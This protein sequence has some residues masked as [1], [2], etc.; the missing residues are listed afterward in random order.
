MTEDIIQELRR[1]LAELKELKGEIS[2]VKSYVSALK[3]DRDEA[4]RTAIAD[5]WTKWVALSIVFLAVAAAFAS[6][7]QGAYSGVGIKEL[8]QAGIEQGRA[9]NEWS[10]YQ[11]ASI[12]LHMYEFERRG[13]AKP[14]GGSE[15][16]TAALAA[17]AGGA[18]DPDVGPGAK[19]DTAAY[20]ASLDKKIGKYAKQKKEIM[21][22]ARGHDKKREEHQIASTESQQH[23]SRLT[24]ALAILQVAIAVGS[25]AAL[26]KKK[27]LWFASL[28]LGVGGILQTLNGIYVWF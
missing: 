10:Y 23:S 3:G 8:Y 25:I 20:I 9:T 15:M 26:A 2:E 11:S 28:A 16:K 13:E 22:R 14:G 6:Q 18:A 1:D 17:I 19:K 21:D 7:R 24:L 5:R 4:K 12:K 27:P